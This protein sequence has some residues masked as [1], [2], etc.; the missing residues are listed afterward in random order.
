KTPSDAVDRALRLTGLDLPA[1]AARLGVKEATLYKAR[2]GHIPL[3]A[4]TA[5]AIDLLLAAHAPSAVPSPAHALRSASRKET[6][7]VPLAALA[8]RL[9]FLH[10]HATDDE[11]AILADT[12]EAF[13]HRVASRRR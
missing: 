11:L 4:R 12:L 6:R 7:S 5:R 1:L 9:A 8:E 13:H 3:S 10:A 2:L